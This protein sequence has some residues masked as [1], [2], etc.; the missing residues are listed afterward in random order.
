MADI[1]IDW[2][3]TKAVKRLQTKNPIFTGFTAY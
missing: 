2:L 1:E 3:Y